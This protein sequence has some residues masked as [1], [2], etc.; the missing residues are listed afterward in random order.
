VETYV[1]SARGDA[2]AFRSA[3]G[4]AGIMRATLAGG[5]DTVSGITVSEWRDRLAKRLTAELT[6]KPAYA[7][8][9][10]IG[11]ADAG[12]EILRVDRSGPGGTIRR[13]PD[14]ELQRKGDRGYFKDAIRMRPDEVYV[15]AIDLNQEQG[16]IETPYVPTL[17]VATSIQTPAGDPFGIIIN[18]A[19]SRCSSRRVTRRMRSSITADSILAFCC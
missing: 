6:A 15:S 18:A 5:R 4:L 19:R 2:I 1:R 17:R 11:V 9:R 13:V 10:I 8:F 14:V 3:I 7:Q 16:V 12:R